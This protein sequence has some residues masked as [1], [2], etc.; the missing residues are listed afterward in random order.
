MPSAYSFHSAWL[1]QTRCARLTCGSIKL[2]R[3]LIETFELNIK[4]KIL[5]LSSNGE[6]ASLSSLRSLLLSL[7]N[8][9]LYNKI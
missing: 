4:S 5:Y 1:R 3:N 8:Y 9:I 7:L 6:F 2:L